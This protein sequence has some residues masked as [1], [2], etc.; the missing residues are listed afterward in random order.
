MDTP[1]KH[2]NVAAFLQSTG[3]AYTRVQFGRGDAIFIQGEP[4]DHVRFIESGAVKVSVTSMT[5]KEGV[6]AL[7]GAGDFLGED[8]LAGQPSYRASAAAI[9]PSMIVGVDKRHMLRLL[10]EQHAMSDRFIAHLLV[11]NMRSEEHLADHLFNSGQQRLARTLL[12]LAGYGKP[13]P[14]DHV[15]LLRISQETL[16]AIVGTTRSRINIFL[17]QFKKRGFIEYRRAG[18]AQDQSVAA[19]GRD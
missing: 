14:P 9:T 10:R 15:L 18:G 6:V 16:A 5:G 8:C 17:R 7:L 11:R 13:S 1:D 4:C 12:L 3:V 19:D 2:L